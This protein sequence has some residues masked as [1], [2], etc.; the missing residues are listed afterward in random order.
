MIP[1]RS[2]KY[3][4]DGSGS[5]AAEFAL[6]VPIFFGLF[7]AI[8]NFGIVIY[9][10]STLHAATQRTAR[11]ISINA[12]VGNSALCISN[13]NAYGLS[14]YA[15]PSIGQSFSYSLPTS[16]ACNGMKLVTGSGAYKIN[17][18]VVSIPVNL[19]AKSCY[20]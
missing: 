13:T 2:R 19:T 9:A 17:A 1:T 12:A 14:A 6:V 3:L 18:L 11:C 5:G 16:G 4:D 7:F 10:N 20:P 8:V 15:G